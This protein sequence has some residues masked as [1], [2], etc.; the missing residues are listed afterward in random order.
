MSESSIG[1]SDSDLPQDE[2]REPQ[3]GDRG[4]KVWKSSIP[5]VCMVGAMALLGYAGA[6][7]L[8]GR[9][10]A[11][12]DLLAEPEVFD[13]GTVERG[14]HPAQIRLLNNSSQQIRIVHVIKSCDCASVQYSTEPFAPGE[15][16]TLDCEWDTAHK[17]GES[18]TLIHVAYKLDRDERLRKMTIGLRGEI[19]PDFTVAPEKIQFERDRAGHAEIQFAATQGADVRL[20][21]V[22]TTHP[23]LTA[24]VDDETQTVYVQ[25]SPHKWPGGAHTPEVLML[26]SSPHEPAFH[27]PVRIVAPESVGDE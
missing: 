17:R 10:T 5:I 20:H 22:S 2:N 26:S 11:D 4:W 6:S 24:A 18:S 27:V 21:S 9:P 12:M 1:V 16:A 23:S 14:Q 25:F 7:V 3:A 8:L 13:F 15:H 19:V